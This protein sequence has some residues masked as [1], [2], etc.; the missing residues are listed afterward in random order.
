MRVVVDTNIAFSAIVNTNSRIASIFFQPKSRLSFY[1][2]GQLL[3]EILEHKGKLK[4]IAGY[5]DR[6]LDRIIA[7]ITGKIRFVNPGFIPGEIY[8]KAELLTRHIDMDDTEF[9]ALTEYMKARFWSGD[10]VLRNGLIKLGWNRFI[11]L[12]ELYQIISE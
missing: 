7:L 9:I 3:T 5:S 12:E 10:K 2:T 6:E 4:R 8:M 1:S 11:S